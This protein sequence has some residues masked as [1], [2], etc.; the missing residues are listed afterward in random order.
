[1]EKVGLSSHL[2]IIPGF[3]FRQRTKGIIRP[4]SDTIHHSRL[5]IKMGGGN[6][7]RAL[8]L[9]LAQSIGFKN[10]SKKFKPFR[11]AALRFIAGETLDEAMAAVRDANSNRIAC[12]LDL[13]GENTQSREDA[14]NAV[15]TVLGIFDRIQVEKVDCNVS[16]KLTQ[17]GLELDPDF[18]AHNL[19]QIVGHARTMGNFVRVDMEDSRHTQETLDLVGRIHKSFG[20]VGTVIQAYLYRSEQDTLRMLEKKI[21]LR[22]VKGAYLEPEAVAFRRKKDTDANY[23]KLAKILLKSDT[24]NAIATHDEA[25]IQAVK[26]FARMENIRKDQFEFQMLFGIRRDL[27]RRLAQEGYS[28]RVYIPYGEFWFPYFMRRLAE[29]PANISFF[30]RNLLRK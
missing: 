15:R 4:T 14:G 29:R 1:M 17:L 18:C 11:A 26:E 5:C 27:Q 13:L 8:L 20:N 22:L 21:R 16:V 19:L 2:D 6:Q 10:F 30:L 12:S 25:I 24:Y 7:M 3:H 9:F 23:L 28:V